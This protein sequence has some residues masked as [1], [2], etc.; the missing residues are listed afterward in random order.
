MSFPP[1]NT[2]PPFLQ[3]FCLSCTYFLILGLALWGLYYLPSSLNPLALIDQQ[4]FSLFNSL[5]A[6][7]GYWAFGSALL[8]SE[9]TDLAMYF[10]VFGISAAALRH[11]PAGE[12][13]RECWRLALYYILLTIAGLG[14]K[15]LVQKY[16][17]FNRL[18][19]T[20][21]Q[22]NAF[23]L[24]K[25]GFTFTFKDSSRR[26]FPGDHALFLFSWAMFWSRSYPRWA[27]WGSIGV[28]FCFSLPRLFVS[29]HWATD[30]LLG[31]WLPAF[32]FAKLLFANPFWNRTPAQQFQ[33][34]V[35]CDRGLK[36]AQ[37]S[38]GLSHPKQELS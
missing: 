6:G 27:W 25:E 2:C 31:G 7:G 29:G 14:F 11:L 33:A 21:T 19:P 3:R 38:Q 37:T 4:V 28:A 30:L 15:T 35:K 5:L 12:K 26:S 9:K 10:A 23:R 18:S 16:F 24:C 1:H 34:G 32:A 17:V 20:L 22:P 36:I 13:R 8:N